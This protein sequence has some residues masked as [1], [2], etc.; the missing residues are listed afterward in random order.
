MARV[1]TI[2]APSSAEKGEWFNVS[3]I[4]YDPVTGYPRVGVTVDLYYSG[5]PLGSTTTGVDGD[6]LKSVRIDTVGKFLLDAVSGHG[7]ASRI[8]T[9]TESAPPQPD[10]ETMITISAPSSVEEAAAFPVTGRLTRE[11][12]GAGLPGQTIHFYIDGYHEALGTTDSGGYYEFTVTINARGS[13][14]L[15]AG[16]GGASASLRVGVG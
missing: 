14:T 2:W 15:T 12:T 3:G 9:I 13:H 10:V 8:I 7:Y 16:F 6:Y 1:V 11:D 5:I 4:V